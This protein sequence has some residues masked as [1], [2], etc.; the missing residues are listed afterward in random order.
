MDDIIHILKSLEKQEDIVQ[1]KTTKQLSSKKLTSSSNMIALKN[2]TPNY[3]GYNISTNS[4]INNTSTPPINI[5][6]ITPAVS[7]T[8]LGIS[9]PKSK[10]TIHMIR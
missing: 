2:N 3:L 4:P 10:Y 1:V 5:H 6:P 7:T 8:N 9:N